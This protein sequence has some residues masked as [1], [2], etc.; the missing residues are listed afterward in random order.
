MVPSVELQKAIYGELS[1]G[2]YPVHEVV[3]QDEEELP[4]ITIQSINRIPNYTK[5]NRKRFTYSIIIDGWSYSRSSY[6][7][8][9]IEE[10]IYQT[11]MDLEVGQFSVELVS[12]VMNENIKEEQTTDRVV[13]HSIQQFELII[14]EK[15][16]D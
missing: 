4:M 1:K 15:G 16:E 12:L 3:P 11:I 10:F 13:H 5:T 6:E 7:I 2:N 14:S 9:G 8:K